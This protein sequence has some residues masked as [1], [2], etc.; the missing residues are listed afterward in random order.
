MNAVPGRIVVR[1]AEWKT[2]TEKGLYLSTADRA[3]LTRLAAQDDDRL[4][5]DEL[6]EGVR[7][8]A[9]SWV[10]VIRFDHFD[11]CVE[12]KL[13]GDN[14]GLVNMIAYTTGL[15]AL[16]RLLMTRTVQA[17]EADL[18]DLLALLFAEACAGVAKRGLLADYVTHEDALPVLRGRL[19]PDRQVIK[20]F[21]RVD[22]IE[23]RYDEHDL[24][25]PDNQI[26][27]SAINLCVGRVKDDAVSR[28][29][30]RLRALFSEICGPTSMDVRLLRSALTYNRRNEHYRDAHNLAWLLI[31]G[32]GV[33][34]VLKSGDTTSF[35]FFIDM[36]RL[37]E[38]FITKVLTKICDDHSLR[39]WNQR[40]DR[41][42]LWDETRGRSYANVIPD[43]LIGQSQDAAWHLPVDAK[44]KRYD[45]YKVANADIYQT[46]LYALAY[47]P[48][49]AA[50]VPQALLLYPS[51]TPQTVQS[52]VT[53]RDM[54][55][56]HRGAIHALGVHIPSLLREVRDERDGTALATIVD[57]I[58]QALMEANRTSQA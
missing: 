18:F 16:R 17:E 41:S 53:V 24:D 4:V 46:M 55:K 48:Q 54:R 45:D 32:L 15:S 21:G 11:V 26:L 35:A 36:N 29:F 2:V 28:Q 27:A 30:K 56:Q 3:L 42:I 5:I 12:P 37:F 19:L 8:T 6:R 47:G 20:Q 51:S 25:I 7:V 9:R 43:L 1:V 38:K 31:D 22:R 58:D 10:G 34:D 39:V 40:K 44:Y 52:V 33:R 57:H 50:Y 14:V 13:A 23:C 49:S